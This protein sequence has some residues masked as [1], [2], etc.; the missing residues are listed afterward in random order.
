MSVSGVSTYIEYGKQSNFTT[1]VSAGAATRAFGLNQEITS[2][3]IDE[4]QFD[5]G[6]INTALIQKYGFGLFE[7]SIGID[8]TLSNPWWLDMVLGTSADTGSASDYTHTYDDSKTVNAFTVE[9]GTDTTTD[10]VLQLQRLTAKEI[11]I[12]TAPN[13]L[14]SCKGSFQFGATPTTAGTSLDASI[15]TDDILYPYTCVQATLEN[16]SGTPLAEV[17]SME[18]TINPNI[19]MVPDLNTV[20]WVNAYKGRLDLTGKFSLS[21]VNNTWWNNVR[22]RAEPSNNTLRLK[23]TN[24]L[25]TTLERTIQLTFTGLGLGKLGMSLPQYELQTEEIAW[26]ARDLTATAENATATP[27]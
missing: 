7:G 25:A 17:Q 20:N 15:V 19:K 8:W 1:A 21:I 18:C 24:G 2:L 14:V 6:D 26:T 5:V 22:A 11:S 9:V 3:S 27:P 13:E 16:P 23:F 4:H 10:R 12:S